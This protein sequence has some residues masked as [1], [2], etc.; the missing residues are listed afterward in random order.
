MLCPYPSEAVRLQFGAYRGALRSRVVFVQGQGANLILHMMAVLM[1]Q[2]VRLGKR[3]SLGTKP[4]AQ[5]LEEAKINIDSAVL[6]AIERPHLRGGTAAAG[7][8][9]VGEERGLCQVVGLSAPG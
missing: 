8:G 6:R 3:T 2:H 7:I 9:V 5:L 1:S 4:G